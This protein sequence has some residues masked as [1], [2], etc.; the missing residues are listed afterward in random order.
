MLEEI[1]ENVGIVECVVRF[2][3]KREEDK[4]YREI[5]N[6]LESECKNFNFVTINKNEEKPK[7][8]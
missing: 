7:F 8:I 1:R 2:K 4:K 5:I 6:F 3:G